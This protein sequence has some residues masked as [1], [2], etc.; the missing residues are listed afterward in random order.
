MRVE[1]T[2]ETHWR[3]PRSRIHAVAH[4]AERVFHFPRTTHINLAFVADPAMQRLHKKALGRNRPTDVLAFPL[5]AFHATRAHVF[6][7][8][9]PDPDGAVRL[10]DVVISV[11]TAREQ[12]RRLGHSVTEEVTELFAHGLLHLLGYNHLRKTDAARMA[13]LAEC[14]LA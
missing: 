11:P 14:L 8:I 12:A 2:S 1:I 9:P 3:V 13:A 5:H 7:N 6:S 4:R 10:G